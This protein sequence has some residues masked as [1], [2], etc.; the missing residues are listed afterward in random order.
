MSLHNANH[1]I[2]FPGLMQFFTLN[3]SCLHI[4]QQVLAQDWSPSFKSDCWISRR[5]R[6]YWGHN[7]DLWDIDI[8]KKQF[9]FVRARESNPLEPLYPTEPVETYDM[10]MLFFLFLGGAWLNQRK[11]YRSPTQLLLWWVPHNLY[12]SAVDDVNFLKEI[13]FLGMDSPWM[14]KMILGGVNQ[15]T[16]DWSFENCLQGRRKLTLARGS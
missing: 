7:N 10:S 4:A 1:W 13:W 5:K 12:S 16:R 14:S 2:C 8:G 15:G 11:I 6:S 3:L 9:G